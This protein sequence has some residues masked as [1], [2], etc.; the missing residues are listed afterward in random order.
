MG[1]VR[2]TPFFVKLSHEMIKLLD[3]DKINKTIYHINIIHV[4]N[5]WKWNGKF[6]NN[7]VHYG[8][9]LEYVFC[10]SNDN[11][12]QCF[13]ASASRGDITKEWVLN[14]TQIITKNK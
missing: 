14:Y 10:N 3:F 1:N 7:H 6:I 8:G 9:A 13:E 11:R 12:G 5:L 4:I 2:Q